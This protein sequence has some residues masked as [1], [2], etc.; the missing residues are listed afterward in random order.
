M[1]K[2]KAAK[3]VSKAAV[4]NELAKVIK[5]QQTLQTNLTKLKG[6]LDAMLHHWDWDFIDRKK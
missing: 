3:K 1:A 4:K 5:T 6:D 2:K